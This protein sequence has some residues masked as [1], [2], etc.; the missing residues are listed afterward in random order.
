MIFE[1]TNI[2]IQITNKLQCS[3]FKFP[4]FLLYN[5]TLTRQKEVGQV[6]RIERIITDQIYIFS[7]RLCILAVKE[8][9]IPYITACVLQ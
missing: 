1:I 7:L 6:K 3:N 8:R 4:N 5:S 9:T 2:K